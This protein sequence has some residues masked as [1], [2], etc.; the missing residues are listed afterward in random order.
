VVAA[1]LVT[2][3]AAACS[4]SGSKQP[5]GADSNAPIDVTL[6]ITPGAVNLMPFFVALYGGFFKKAGLNLTAVNATAAGGSYNELL[7]SGKIDFGVLDIPGIV[8]L[9]KAGGDF[10]VVDVYEQRLTYA[11][12]CR[13]GVAVTTGY[14]DGI[15]SIKPYTIGING[16]GSAQVT[17]LLYTYAAAGGNPKDLKLVSLGTLANYYAAFEAKRVDC[18]INIPPFSTV[19]TQQGYSYTTVIDWAKG[20]GPDIF[21]DYAASLTDTTG[22]FANENP[23]AIKRFQ[24]AMKNAID[25]AGNPANA[26][27]IAKDVSPA[28]TGLSRPTLISMVDYMA[29]AY[30][31]APTLT[32]QQVENAL[33]VYSIA[34]SQPEPQSVTLQSLLAIP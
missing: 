18:F 22:T 27:A 25:Y 16:P 1:A 10:K 6:G 14:P 3:L 4:A 20:Q 19:L 34:N 13:P 9:N 5:A 29:T 8:G 23:V 12:V 32:Q 2:V 21:R 7:A 17:D 28:F 24:T 15:L 11:L 26:A 33:H 31:D 30:G